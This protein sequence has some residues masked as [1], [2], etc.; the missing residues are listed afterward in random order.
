MALTDTAIRNAKP[1][2]K[3]WRLKDGAKGLRDG[4]G[5]YLVIEPNGAKLFRM[6]YR[7]PVTGTPNTLSLGAYPATSLASARAKRDEA[8][9]LLAQG[10]DPSSHRKAARAA[11]REQAA[12]SFEVIARE[13]LASKATGWEPSHTEKQKSRLEKHLLPR[14]GDKPISEITVAD[15]RPLLASM[16]KYVEQLHRVMGIASDVFRFAIATGR[17]ENDPAHTLK[18]ALPPRQKQ[19][20]PTITDPTRIG[21]LLRAIDGY[22]TGTLQVK[23]ALRLAP[24]TFVRPGELRMARGVPAPWT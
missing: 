22:D 8:R 10:I 5:L 15:L 7:R 20:F 23:C 9:Q 11:G 13:W 3:R 21:G 6:D 17:A 12:N 24:L 4:G 1:Q 18:A 14:I 2:P 19:S 16:T